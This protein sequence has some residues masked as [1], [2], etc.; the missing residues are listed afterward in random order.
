MVSKVYS[1]EVAFPT[2]E[3][4]TQAT[5]RLRS[6]Q[7]TVPLP[8]RGSG[9]SAPQEAWY[10]LV[11]QICAVGSS[12]S[13]DALQSSAARE[14]L[15]ILRIRSEGENA[16]GYVHAVLA[17]LKV[18]Y[19]SLRS[20]CS[21]KA[22]AIT[23]NAH[24]PFI[25]DAQGAVCLL[26]RITEVVGKPG[27]QGLLT[28]EQSRAARR[29]L[30]RNVQFFGPKSAS[31]FLIGLGLVDCF[32]ALD[33]R[34]LNLLIDQWGFDPVWRDRVHKLDE[35]EKLESEVIARFCNSLEIKPAEL[36]RL[37]FYG[38]SALRK[39]KEA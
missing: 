15:T 5:E 13:W 30:I 11:G 16:P 2:L 10:R 3:S 27:D 23:A 34:L 35:Y 14:S 18:R 1:R 29:L 33:V 36:D 7:G 32:L 21:P 26:D 38:Y 37:L 8:K 39:S 31:D 25:A 19:C 12:R 20:E 6:L 22:R 17:G 28:L 24:S 4:L 9:W